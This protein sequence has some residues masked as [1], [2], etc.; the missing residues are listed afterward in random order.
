M[1]NVKG[2]DAQM[3]RRTV[4]KGA[5]WAAPVVTLGVAAPMAAA[6]P[7]P[8]FPELDDAND[9]WCKHSNQKIYHVGLIWNNTLAC[10]TTVSIV[11][12]NI[13]PFSGGGPVPVN[14]VPDS[15]LIPE[16]STTSRYYHSIEWGT[17][18]NGT[19]TVQYKYT[20]CSGTATG[21]LTVNLEADEL[22]PCKNVP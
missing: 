9:N 20:D 17:I 11:S 1:D 7:P 19:A 10:D 12:I 16:G 15:F 2:A 18:A 22:P 3:K 4:V 8:V 21:V 5:A 14:G 6:S 13:Y